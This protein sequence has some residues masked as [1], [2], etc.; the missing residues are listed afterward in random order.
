VEWTPGEQG[1]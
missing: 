1:Q